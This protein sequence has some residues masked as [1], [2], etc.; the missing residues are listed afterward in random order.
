MVGTDIGVAATV[1]YVRSQHWSVQI[2]AVALDG[3]VATPWSWSH[4]RPVPVDAGRPPLADGG[5]THGMS[6]RTSIRYEPAPPMEGTTDDIE[7]LSLWAGQ[8]VALAREPQPAAEIVA[9]LVSGL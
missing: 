6:V 7:A 8:S 1:V 5:V 4:R 3:G 2:P 9:Q